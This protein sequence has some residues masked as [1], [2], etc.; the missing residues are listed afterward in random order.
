LLREILVLNV[1]RKSR[2]EWLSI[3]DQNSRHVRLGKWDPWHVHVGKVM[4]VD[5]HG[6]G[7]ISVV[8]VIFSVV[9]NKGFSLRLPLVVWG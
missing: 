4:V 6:I 8:V 2:E 7:S 1:S 3:C 9:T 5:I